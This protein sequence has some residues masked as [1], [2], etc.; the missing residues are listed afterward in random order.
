[1]MRVHD[2]IHDEGHFVRGG[3]PCEDALR[4]MIVFD[5]KFDKFSIT[6]DNTGILTKGYY[7]IVSAAQL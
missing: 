4:D 5:W 3:D 1:M 2:H 7:K 6:P